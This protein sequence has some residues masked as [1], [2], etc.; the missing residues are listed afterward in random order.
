MSA[1]SP[2]KYSKDPISNLGILKL[3]GKILIFCRSRPSH[4]LTTT[5]VSI[6]ETWLEK[7]SGRNYIRSEFRPRGDCKTKNKLSADEL[8]S[9]VM[10][11][12]IVMRMVVITQVVVIIMSEM[13]MWMIMEI[14]KMMYVRPV[15]VVSY[16]NN[17]YVLHIR[18]LLLVPV[19]KTRN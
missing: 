16:C 18:N 5:H 6:L 19:K 13:I 10:A 4:C 7:V 15:I 1:A 9:V 12:A 3:V 17:A 11:H 8:R 2:E 14:V